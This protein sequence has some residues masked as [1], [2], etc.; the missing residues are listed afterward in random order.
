MEDTVSMTY[1]YTQENINMVHKQLG[2]EIVGRIH[3]ILIATS[4]GVL[5][6]RATSLRLS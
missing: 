3:L 5:G 1:L 6:T 4:G 2:F